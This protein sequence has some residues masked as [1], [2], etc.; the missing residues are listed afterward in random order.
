MVGKAQKSHRARSEL[1]SVFDL[2]KVDRWNPIRTYAIQSRS[3]LTRFLGFSNREKGAQRQE[4]SKWSAV[5]STF[6]GSGWSVVRS[7]SLS[8]G[9]T[10]KKRPSPHLHIVPTWSNKV[11]PRTFHTALVYRTSVGKPEGKTPLGRPRRMSVDNITTNLKEIR[12]EGMDWMRLDQD[13]DQWQ[14]IFWLAEWLL[15]FQRLCSMELEA[16]QL[17]SL[18][19]RSFVSG[20]PV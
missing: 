18:G 20:G 13:R 10:P 9:L 16:T 6:S 2:E 4:I 1:N 7:S 14:G 3:R 15:A 17:L 8:K 19:V 12:W 5:C 11:S